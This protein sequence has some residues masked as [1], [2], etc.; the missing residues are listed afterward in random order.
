MRMGWVGHA[1]AGRRELLTG[2]GA[3][4]YSS[5]AFW[6]LLLLAMPELPLGGMGLG[7]R[8]ELLDLGKTRKQ[9][10][11]AVRDTDEAKEVEIAIPPKN[12]PCAYKTSR[13][14]R[15]GVVGNGKGAPAG[16]T[17]MDDFLS[18]Q[19]QVKYL[20]YKI[21]GTRASG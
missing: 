7:V 15:G 1:A 2:P 19:Q 12:I 16:M 9:R 18:F 13:G 14:K 4:R 5:Q 3:G 6:P 17:S 10:A 11:P 21:R 20:L 8:A